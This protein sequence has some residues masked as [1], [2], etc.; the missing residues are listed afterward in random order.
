MVNIKIGTKWLKASPAFNKELCAK[1]NVE[2][3]EFD[4]KSSSF[5]QQ[6]NSEGSQFMEYVDDYGYF[7]DVPLAFMKKNIEEHYPHI[8]KPGSDVKEFKL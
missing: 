5:L 6:Y 8:F 4:G 1:F 3:L 7:E 2:P